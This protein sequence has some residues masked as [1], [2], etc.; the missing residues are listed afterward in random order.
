MAT[1]ELLDKF[2]NENRLIQIATQEDGQLW[3]CNVY[4]AS[5][6][7]RNIYWTSARHRRHSVEIEKNPAVAAAIVH[8][9]D[10]K[11][12]VQIAGRAYRIPVDESEAAD[13]IYSDKLGHKDSRLE[14]VRQDTPES[15][16]Y[17]I[18]RPDVIE[19]WDEVNFPDKPKQRVQL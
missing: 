19:L 11:Q 2:L 4:F 5:D 15:R 1:I 10:K 9:E 14:E 3:I 7:D 16:A 12:A 8:S 18:L 13:R 17:W 6:K